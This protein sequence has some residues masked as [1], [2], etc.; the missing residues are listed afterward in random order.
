VVPAIDLFSS[1]G[2]LTI[3]FKRAGI[4]TISAV[5]VEPYRVQTFRSH[6]PEAELIEDDIRHVNFARFKGHVRLVYGGP[7][8]QPFSSGGL[9]KADQDE[10]NMI[11][12][13]VEAVAVIRPDAF[14]MEN[15]PGL[16][17]NDRLP[18]LENV[19]RKF[20]KLGYSVTWKVLNAADYG[21]PQKRRRLF[22][23]GMLNRT[24]HF[25]VETHGP[26][27][28]HPH[29]CVRDVLPDHQLGE[30]NPS[31]VFYAKRPDLRPSPY[32]GHLFNGGGRPIDRSQPCH[33]ILASAGGN[34]THFFDDLGLV[35]AY[36][37]HLMRGGK[38][39]TGAL[40]GARR[41]TVLE[42]A[43]IQTFPRE[44]SFSGP[45]CAQ[46]QQVGDAVPPLLAQVIASSLMRQMAGEP[47]PVA[48]PVVCRQ[49]LLWS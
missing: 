2:G 11:P 40:K 22:V 43:I 44:I 37:K 49:P 5:E 45:R 4:R 32:D 15:V 28:R 38:P 23:I 27:R 6:T 14:V 36:H 34:K 31:H 41:L 12:A 26:G 25:P 1:A 29:V 48:E 24:F 13:Y 10:R 39:R 21:V 8:C 16:V 47:G 17:V 9:R 3:G 30:P 42:S 18:Y 33:T 20:Q 19:V 35:P 7:P 46:Y